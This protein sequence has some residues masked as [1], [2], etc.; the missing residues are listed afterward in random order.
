MI[1]D[2]LIS[3]EG[4]DADGS[5]L[6]SVLITTMSFGI[7]VHSGS[8]LH[9]PM[10]A[11]VGPELVIAKQPYCCVTCLPCCFLCVHFPLSVEGGR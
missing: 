8:E 4:A 3:N 5:H 10:L 9:V 11:T 1:V 2:K 6:K 7:K